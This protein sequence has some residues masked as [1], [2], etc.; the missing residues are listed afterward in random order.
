[1]FCSFEFILT[2]VG[3]S[4]FSLVMLIASKVG[5]STLGPNDIFSNAGF[6]FHVDSLEQKL[7]MPNKPGP[8]L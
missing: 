7:G 2:T 5:A 3:M 6:S 4:S 1:M 8:I